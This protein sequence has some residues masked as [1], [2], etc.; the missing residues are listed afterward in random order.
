MFASV[1]PPSDHLCA[2]AL[3]RKWDPYSQQ[4][5][6]FSEKSYFDGWFKMTYNKIGHH[7]RW[8]CSFL[9]P[10]GN[11]ANVQMKHPWVGTSHVAQAAFNLGHFEARCRSHCHPHMKINHS[12]IYKPHTSLLRGFLKLGPLWKVSVTSVWHICKAFMME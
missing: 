7:S 6:Y 5:D 10:Q 11:N 9:T 2:S 3:I 1:L 12:L 4:T 8:R